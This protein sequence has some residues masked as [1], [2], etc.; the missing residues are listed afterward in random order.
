MLTK[1]KTESRKA[2]SM[3]LVFVM[4]FT[5]MVLCNP[6]EAEA[7][8][9]GDF[10]AGEYYYYPEGTH[11]ISAI[12]FSVDNSSSTASNNLTNNGYSV[13]QN[14]N[15]NNSGNYNMNMK[16]N[17]GTTSYPYIFLGYKT[18]TDINQALG[19]ALRAG[20][21]DSE[22]AESMTWKLKN[23]AGTY[24]S[25]PFKKVSGQDLNAKVGGD[26]VY[27]YYHNPKE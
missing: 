13:L 6:F 14:S 21:S 17:S 1:I 7:L 4:C 15:P 20:I 3:L 27:L 23:F 10:K 22:M 2:L 26:Y 16:S 11:F 25:I 24:D 18:T 8:G 5:A 12:T 9:V 19:T